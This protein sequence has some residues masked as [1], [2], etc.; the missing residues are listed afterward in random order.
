MNTPA[1]TAQCVKCGLCLPHCPTFRLSGTETESPRGRIAL[2]EF[3]NDQT[4]GVSPGVINHLDSCLEC[5][6][7]EAMCPSN[8]QFGALMDTAR[9]QLEIHRNRSLSGKVLRRLGFN[10]VTAG[11]SKKKLLVTLLRLYRTLGVQRLL[12]RTHILHGSLQ[13]L[14]RL[15]VRTPRYFETVKAPL[16]DS[17]CRHSSASSRL[18]SM[19]SGIHQHDK[20]GIDHSLLKADCRK[21]TAPVVQLFTGCVSSILDCDAL[22]AARLLLTHSGFCV[23]VNPGQVCCGAL[24]QHNGESETARALSLHNTNLY[25]A[26][27]EQPVIAIA[28]GCAA[29]LRSYAEL[30]NDQ[31]TP[32]FRR[33]IVDIHRL[34]LDH[35]HFSALSFL[36]LNASVAVHLPCTQRHVLGD[37]ESP[38]QLLKKIPDI[39]LQEMSATAGCCGAA[40]SYCLTRPEQSDQLCSDTLAEIATSPPDYLVTSNTGCALHMAASIEASGWRTEVLHPVTLLARQLHK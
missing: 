6:A 4:T 33:Q 17:S 13:R 26:H 40:G 27:A 9:Q 39:R 22:D 29:Q 2:I 21:T 38:V 32:E 18:K 15:L 3:L 20:K 12:R 5:L 19:D 28:S 16:I 24:H 23:E 30:Y 36:P 34:L 10:L 37:A 7:C 31:V 14:D 35:K 1:T 8:V 11:T 25:T